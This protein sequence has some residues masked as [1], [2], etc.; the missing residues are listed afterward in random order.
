VRM[1]GGWE[2]LGAIVL[3]GHF[4]LP[5]C[6]LLVRAVKRSSVAMA[7]LGAWLIIMHFADVYWIVMPDARFSGRWGYVADVGAI[8]LIGGVACATWVVRR[9][10]EA[11]VPIGDPRLAASLEYSTE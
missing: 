9:A 8:L 7:L 2:V 3:F 5:F 11:N 6:A 10:G 4:A 1:R